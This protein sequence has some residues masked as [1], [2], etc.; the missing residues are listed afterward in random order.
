MKVLFRLSAKLISGILHPLFMPTYALLLL[1]LVNPYL[2]GVSDLLDRS[3]LI[4]RI[5]LMTFFMPFL[6]VYLMWYLQLVPSFHLPN[7]KERIVPYIATSIFYLWV[8]LNVKNS[9]WVPKPYV[10]FMLGSVIS[11]FLAFFLNNFTK[12]SAHAIGMGGFIGFVVLGLATW[13][14]EYFWFQWGSWGP[15]ELRLSRVLVFVV[16]LAGLVG[17]SRLLLKVH[18]HGQVAMGFLV[19]LAAQYLASFFIG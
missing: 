8:F 1:L 17:S 9:G 11:L 4:L 3:F 6:V 15:W 16:L 14:Y 2:F 12:I 10:A 18:T 13:H 5:F 7:R 19:G